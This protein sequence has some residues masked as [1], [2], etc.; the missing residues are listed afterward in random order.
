M[1]CKKLSISLFLGI[2]LMLLSLCSNSHNKPVKELL[3]KTDRSLKQ[4][5]SLVYKIKRTDKTFTGR[6]TVNSVAICSLYI[7]SN[8]T[9]GMLYITDTR[10]DEEHSL[11][12]QVYD[13]KKIL[14]ASIRKDSVHYSTKPTTYDV[15]N[16]NDLQG[17]HNSI[18]LCSSFFDRSHV[19]TKADDLDKMKVSEE[20][21]H[22]IPVYVLTVTGEDYGDSEERISNSIDKY[23]ISKKDYLPIAYSFYG[24]FQGMKQYEFFDMEYISINPDLTPDDFKV[25]SKTD[26]VDAYALYKKNES[27]ML[28]DNPAS[29]KKAEEK[30]KKEMQLAGTNMKKY[31]KVPYETLQLNNR[32]TLR[33]SDLKGKIV[34]LDFWYRGCLPCL[35]ATP[36][37]MKLQEK[38]QDDLVVIGINDADDK[39]QVT[40]YY[41]YKKVPYFSSYSTDLHIAKELKINAFP[42]FIILNKKGELADK[43]E[44]FQKSKIE[45]TISG[46]IR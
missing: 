4:I 27:L 14:T 28:Y 5:K 21:Y 15:K 12:H 9:G 35:K 2:C 31:D 23:Y 1:A 43:I 42:T 20:T 39:D 11:L 19:F 25:P 22:G 44:G 30:R 29:Q 46:L 10:L 33:I 45:Q 17:F 3:D 26:G 18:F 8:F 16:E 24:E 13:G 40:D 7:D 34:L 6:D 32:Q 37:L 38:Y 36:E 41:N